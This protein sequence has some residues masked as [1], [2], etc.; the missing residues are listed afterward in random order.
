MEA[1]QTNRTPNF[2]SCNTNPN[3]RHR[4]SVSH[5]TMNCRNGYVPTDTF[6]TSNV[7]AFERELEK[8]HPDNRN[9]RAKVRTAP[10]SFMVVGLGNQFRFDRGRGA[11]QRWFVYRWKA[12]KYDTG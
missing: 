11:G 2:Y 3:M 12:G 1:I 5:G 8:L 4:D 6:T 7:C 10:F 9:V